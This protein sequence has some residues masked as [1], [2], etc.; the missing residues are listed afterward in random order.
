MKAQDDVLVCL[1]KIPT[2]V[3]YHDMIQI[4][5]RHGIDDLGSASL[6]RPFAVVQD[7]RN[8][9]N[10]RGF[11]HGLPST[12]LQNG[13][14]A[15]VPIIIG[16]NLDEGTMFAPQDFKDEKVLEEHIRVGWI[17]PR[18]S[19]KASNLTY[20]LLSKYPDDP[21]R[22]SPYGTGPDSATDP[23]DRLFHPLET[24]QYKRFSSIVG[25]TIF[26]SGRRAQAVAASKLGVPVW[27]YIFEHYPL[28]PFGLHWGVHHGA[29]I[30]YAFGVYATREDEHGD[31]AKYL[32]TAWVNFAYD[33]DPN[34]P[35][36][37][38]KAHGALKENALWPRYTVDERLVL[39][40]RSRE[41]IKD[42]YRANSIEWV[43]LNPEFNW[44]T[45][46]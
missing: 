20:Q 3:L 24:N 40:I 34:G 42:D 33:L 32:A 31:V 6:H 43:G 26:E 5:A 36:S 18:E 9:E 13:H 35:S 37:P 11:F 27:G 23:K 44:A 41:V 29:E 45:R 39:D 8:G 1:R 30:P 22:G 16:A 25:D 28:Q 15:K 10:S 12:A 21:S 2:Q 38:G 14:M 4:M 17:F 7:A 19:S 46:R